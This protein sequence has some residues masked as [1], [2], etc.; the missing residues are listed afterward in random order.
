VQVVDNTGISRFPA[1]FVDWN[2]EDRY[3]PRSFSARSINAA[4]LLRIKVRNHVGVC[5]YQMN[6]SEAWIHKQLGTQSAAYA[7][8]QRSLTWT[9]QSCTF[10][11]CYGTLITAPIISVL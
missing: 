9:H 11:Q 2:A 8:N 3:H 1:T 10:I 4:A 6:R 7:R 5:C